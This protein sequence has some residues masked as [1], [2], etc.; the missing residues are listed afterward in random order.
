MN[1]WLFILPLLTAFTGWLIVTLL[2][3]SFVRPFQ[4][5]NLAGF[6]IQGIFF[7]Q[8]QAIA[9]KVGEIAAGMVA[10]PGI[11]QRM[12]DPKNVEKLKPFIESHVDDFLRIKLKEQIPMISMF[13]GD[14][15]IHML[16]NVFMQELETLFPQVMAKFA[17]NLATEKDVAEFVSDQITRVAP[18]TIEHAFYQNFG[19][20]IRKAQ[21]FGFV[22][23]C[24]AGLIQLVILYFLLR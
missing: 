7:R 1:Y 4:P 8:Q 23:G 21:R 22:M 5:V 2:V 17:E 6:K 3:R 10:S 9:R 11:Q 16:K 14:K 13:I 18:L 20:E 24:L 19:A 12:G 15:T